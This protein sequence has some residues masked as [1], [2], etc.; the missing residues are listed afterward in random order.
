M[1]KYP[2]YALY[3]CCRSN[4]GIID[5][6]DSDNDIFIPSF[7]AEE[8]K[9]FEVTKNLVLWTLVQNAFAPATQKDSRGVKRVKAV[10]KSLPKH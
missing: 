5:L 4:A 6:I 3:T 10:S 7:N 1:S 2:S 9:E 8:I